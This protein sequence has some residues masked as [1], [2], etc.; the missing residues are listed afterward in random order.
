MSDGAGRGPGR[1]GEVERTTKETAIKVRL[2]L[3]GTGATDVATGVGFFDHIHHQNG[4]APNGI[5]LHPVLRI[6]R[7]AGH[8]YV[9]RPAG[10]EPPPVP[11]RH[12]SGRHRKRR[13]P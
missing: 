12:H 4:V 11:Q 1:V 10:E 6:A 7:A 9:A 8:E 3:D 2:D 5:E 13:K